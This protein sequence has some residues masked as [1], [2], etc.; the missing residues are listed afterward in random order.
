[1]AKQKEV[2]ADLFVDL[3]GGNTLSKAKK[4]DDSVPFADVEEI[5]Q[6]DKVDE[7]PIKKKRGGRTNI[8]EEIPVENVKGP[9][10]INI[11]ELK[12]ETKKENVVI[13]FMNSEQSEEFIKNKTK[14]S[15]LDL[16]LEDTEKPKSDFEGK[17]TEDIRA[18]ILQ[19]EEQKSQQFKPKDY[20]EVASMVVNVI[21]MLLSSLLKWWAKDSS[22]TAYSLNKAKKDTVSYQLTLIMIKHQKKWSIEFMFILTI[23]AIYSGPVIAANSH[24]K[25]VNSG[26]IK[27]RTKGKPGKN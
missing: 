20:E 25:K 18:Q 19:E 8:K 7:K 27:G 5:K 9:E 22:D 10:N 15:T 16:N 2:P 17:T 26:E 21:D 11:D 4:S 14:T 13:D 6:D 1:M 12:Q 24:R 3:G 23:L